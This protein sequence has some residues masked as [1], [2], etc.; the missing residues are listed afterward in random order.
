MRVVF[1]FFFKF[2]MNIEMNNSLKYEVLKMNNI[3]MDDEFIF[4]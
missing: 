3:A 1:A 4:C 2:K